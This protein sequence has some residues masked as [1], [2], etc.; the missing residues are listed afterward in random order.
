MELNFGVFVHSNEA[1][2]QC[3]YGEHYYTLEAAGYL[4]KWA[5]EKLLNLLAFPW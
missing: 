5:G 1:S 2:N 3:E 4:V